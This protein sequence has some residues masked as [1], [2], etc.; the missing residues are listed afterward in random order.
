MHSVTCWNSQLFSKIALVGSKGLYPKFRSKN[1]KLKSNN[2]GMERGVATGL[3]WC[4]L[5]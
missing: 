2:V 5:W 4:G 3:K 1:L